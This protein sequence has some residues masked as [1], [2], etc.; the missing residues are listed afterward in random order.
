MILFGKSISADGNS[1][2]KNTKSILSKIPPIAKKAIPQNRQP[3]Q[4]A[5]VAPK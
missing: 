2:W 5:I 3:L 4:N 1:E